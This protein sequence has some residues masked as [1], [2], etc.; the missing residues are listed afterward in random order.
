MPS[1]KSGRPLLPLPLLASVMVAV[2][3]RR[4]GALLSM[5]TNRL[6]LVAPAARP[7]NEPPVRMPL[8][9]LMVAFR[10]SEKP[11]AAARLVRLSA[12]VTTPP[13]RML[14]SATVPGVTALAC[15][16]R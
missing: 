6:L 5:L 3:L 10:L 12:C 16:S 4:P 9:P 14:P 1:A 11:S 8:L 7:A 2:P 15:A 13:A